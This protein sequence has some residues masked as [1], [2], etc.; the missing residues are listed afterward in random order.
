MTVLQYPVGA[1][2]IVTRVLEGGS[3]DR[4]VVCLHGAGSRAD[5]WRPQFPLLTAAGHHVYALDLPGH[6]LADKPRDAPYGAGWFA[7]VV[8]SFIEDHLASTPVVLLGTSLGGHVASTLAAR[9]P[10]L[11]RGVVLIGA[12]GLVARGPEDRPATSP[13]VDPGPAGVRR[14]LEFLVHDPALVDDA[15]VAEEARIN[16]S[17]GAAEA[18]AEVAAYATSRQNDELAADGLRRSGVPT[19]LCW[20]EQDRWVPLALGVAAAEVLPGVELVTVPDAGHAP[21]FERPEAFW[22]V[23]EPFL[24]S[25]SDDV[26]HVGRSSWAAD[27]VLR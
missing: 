22:A 1:A 8:E 23:V 18:L 9:R 2:G 5:R 14:K 16:S 4:V 12:V 10:D 6:G 21:Y 13:I 19:L 17:P 11:V 7:E 27:A 24:S 25:L 20:G 15:W 3:G 26:A